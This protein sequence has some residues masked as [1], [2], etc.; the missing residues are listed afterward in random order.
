[1]LNKQNGILKHYK[2]HVVILDSI[3]FTQNVAKLLRRQKRII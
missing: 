1:M 2:K 3:P